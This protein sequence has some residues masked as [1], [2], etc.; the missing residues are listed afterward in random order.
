MMSNWTHAICAPCWNKERPD[1]PTPL[2]NEIGDLEVC[3]FCGEPTKSGIYV[4]KDPKELK[5][6]AHRDD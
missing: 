3:C 5:H 4:R 2:G 6:C 1:R